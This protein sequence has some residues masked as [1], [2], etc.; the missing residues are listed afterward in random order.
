MKIEKCKAGIT[1]MLLLFIASFKA[2]V[3]ET[4]LIKQ[5]S[6][7]FNGYT[8]T[9]D[10]A[11][12][13][14]NTNGNVVVSG[15]K[16]MSATQYDV[17]TAAQI[18]NG[19]IV[20]SQSF[21]TSTDKAWTTASCHDASGNIY[22][23]GA[24]RTG[25]ANG[26]DYLVIMYDSGGNQQWSA[27]YNGPNS[28]TDVA[29]AVVCDNS[30]NVYVTGASEGTLTAVMDYATVCFDGSG[31][32]QWV[33]RYNY[34]NS[35]DVATAIR[36]DAGSPGY[37]VV[38]GSS[39]SSFTSY[40]FA[41]VKYNASTGAQII[42]SR[43]T[44]TN[45]AAQ[46]QVS[47]MVTD[48][49]GNIYI[50]G[51]TKN[52]TNYD[53]NLVKL[54]SSLNVLWET[55]FDGHGYD[56]AGVNLA[57]DSNSNIYLTG[58]SHINSTIT[59]ML[60]LKFDNSGNLKWKYQE[61][62]TN[63]SPNAEGIR[64]KVKSKNEIFVGGN[65][66][67]N[68][69]Q[70]IA[71]YCLDSLGKLKI[72]QLYNGP[73]GLKDK[74]LDM[75]LADSNF[76]YV[77]ARTYSAGVDNNITI[78][79]QYRTISMPTATLSGGIKYVGNEVI[80][81]FNKKALR[82]DTINDRKFTFGVLSDFVHDSTVTKFSSALSGGGGL[83]N[84]GLLQT[85]KI[86]DFTQADSL[87]LSRTGNNIK[88]PDFYTELLI[89]LPSTISAVA[90]STLFQT[91]KP[92]VHWSDINGISTVAS[93]PK[94]KVEPAPFPFVT[95]N[96]SSVLSAN[97][98][99]YAIQGSLKTVPGY[100][101][102]NINCDS[103]WT[104]T[105]GEPNIKVGIFDTGVYDQHADFAGVFVS[106][107][108]FYVQQGVQ[109]SANWDSA[110]HGTP[111]AGVIGAVRNNNLG[112][113]GIAGG[114]KSIN[115]Q[116]VSLYD[117]YCVNSNVSG[118]HSY[119]ANAIAKGAM[120]GSN[121]LSLDVMNL[122][123]FLQGSYINTVVPGAHVIVPQMNFA[124]RNGVSMVASK[125]NY[126][127][128][129]YTYPADYSEETT[130]SVGSTGTDGHHAIKNT[131][132]NL[133]S[134][135]WGNLD[136]LAPGTDS[137][138]KSTSASG[139]YQVIG[140]TSLATPHV[141]GA[142]SLL[143]SYV[144]TVTP[145]WDNLVHEDCENMLQKT[146]YD[147]QQTATY[148]EKSGYDSVSGWGRINVNQALKKLNKN[149]YKI[150]HIDETHFS[151]SFTRNSALVH[152]GLMMQ[153]PSY[154]S[155][156]AGTYTTNVYELTTTLNYTLPP[157]EQ[158]LDAWPLF[159]E[160]YG[161]RDSSAIVTDRPY[162][163][164]IVSYNSTQAVLKTYYYHNLDYNVYMPFP[165]VQCKSAFSLYTYD[166]SGTI[167]VKEVASETK[168]FTLYPNPNN[169]EYVISFISKETEALTYKVSNIIG[170]QVKIGIYKSQYGD[171]NLKI[172]MSDLTNGVYILNIF[173]SKGLV[174]KQKVIK[175]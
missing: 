137:L 77:S 57:L 126:Q 133:E 114:D 117:M 169:G 80:V 72:K 37:I 116:G 39:G 36:Y 14:V 67:N 153:W 98:P 5:V 93:S 131:N 124:N 62:S 163:C 95:T 69:G 15:N 75:A 168:N 108:D 154:S 47:S 152:S 16:K 167:G 55:H 10:L 166:P 139:F 70:D 49:L 13:M 76:I 175:Q 172:N 52:A 103:A 122:S 44:N 81:K 20:W 159:K 91:I 86:F 4:K 151:T 115:K 142:V 87:S 174:Y 11:P 26:L 141:A 83:V 156:P 79:Y 165:Q 18:S 41:T 3:L 56:D 157:N 90:S 130:M 135:T 109:V 107:W 40:D 1:L 123:I 48:A 125:G 66:G 25:T 121:G 160:S 147:L 8:D 143:M 74:L 6:V 7:T 170:Q 59:E 158:V 97:D 42:T 27:T 171:N 71:I 146:C 46:D 132:S 24:I 65:M 33:A 128:G 162:H 54:D 118:I 50:A 32:Q 88:V 150:R 17:S 21:N 120:G 53:V 58:V 38:S 29:S 19:I 73:A 51:T 63:G 9:V 149:F 140:G 119:V 78:K 89:T 45:A 12:I 127:L 43:T 155:I 2:Q 102:V 23:V 100:T 30:G 111:V 31:N 173:D 105:T 60:V 148:S 22:V 85:R 110:D 68:S 64:I 136:F 94:P 34:S 106:S 161:T 104:I 99:Y 35:I 61:R 92:D 101:N 144:N 129:F 145:T 164:K 134:A 28:T 112:I 82:L 138:V 96:S 84:A 113:A